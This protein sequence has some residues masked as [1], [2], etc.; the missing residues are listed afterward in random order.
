MRQSSYTTCH[1]A[2]RSLGV[3]PRHLPPSSPAHNLSPYLSILIAAK[4]RPRPTPQAPCPPH[5][6][7]TGDPLRRQVAGSQKPPVPKQ[8]ES[9]RLPP[10]PTLLPGCLEAQETKHEKLL[11]ASTLGC[12]IRRGLGKEKARSSQRLQERATRALGKESARISEKGQVSPQGRQSGRGRGPE[13]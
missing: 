3:W 8:R 11:R 9:E 1:Q 10:C 6:L 4:S 2:C 12:L 7:G 5:Y 13:G